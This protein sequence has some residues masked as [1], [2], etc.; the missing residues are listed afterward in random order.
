MKPW[1]Q[2]VKAGW[3][4][5]MFVHMLAYPLAFLWAIAAIPILINMLDQSAITDTRETT[6]NLGLYAMRVPVAVEHVLW[7]TLVPAGLALTIGNILA[8]WLSVKPQE[9]WRKTAALTA[10]L[11]A[12]GVVVAIVTWVRLFV[13]TA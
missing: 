13:T 1:R 9:R 5:F 4:P 11:F 3:V 2:T 12:V 8:V 7:R 10:S 6:L